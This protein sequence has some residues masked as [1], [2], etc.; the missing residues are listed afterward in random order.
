MLNFGNA[1]RERNAAD[2]S[3]P[4]VVIAPDSFKGSLDASAV[5]AAMA[6]GIKRVRPD[7]QVRVCP[8]ADGGEGTLN[9]VAGAGAR[10]LTIDVQGAAGAQRSAAVGLLPDGSALIESAEIVGLTDPA[11]TSVPV[12]ERSTTGVGEA[13]RHVLDLGVTTIYLALGGSSTNDGGA[14]LLV[15]LGARL[16]D[17][18]GNEVRP[19]PAQLSRVATVDI[20]RLDERLRHAVLI[21]MSDVKSPLTGRTGATY[22]FGPQKGVTPEQLET[23]DQ[24]LAR[25]AD[26]V[27]RAFD[28][29]AREQPG[30]GAAGGL[31]FALYML[32]ANL[33]P[34]GEVVARKI[35]LDR[36][37]Q[38]ADWLLTGE[39]RS[40]GQ[41]LSGK[42]PFIAA[43]LAQAASVPATLLS[44]SVDP[45]SLV[46]LN[47][48]FH[49]CFSIAPGPIALEDAMQNTAAYLANQAEQLA[50]LMLA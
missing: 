41:T 2:R 31:G 32:G 50:R 19:V 33:E 23:T 1:D 7:A 30:A 27:E 14:G 18:E 38:G 49:G 12:L 8:M 17:A 20:G 42:A 21:G 34:G 22:I 4:I 3:A 47:G 45:F 48:H 26:A 36:A 37:L 9:A 16:L 35:G 5:A 43:R 29:T 6:E 13:I 39:G 44:G 25:F 15:A 24:C 46:D 11:G 10:L 40:D 28:R